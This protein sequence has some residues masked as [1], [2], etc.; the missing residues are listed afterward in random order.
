M[1]RRKRNRSAIAVGHDAFL[2]IV[3]NLVGIL[4]ILVVVLGSQSSEVIETIKSAESSMTEATTDQL[5]RIAAASLRAEAAARDSQHLE[6]TI[7]RQEAELDLHRQARDQLLDL[8]SVARSALDDHRKSLDSQHAEHVRQT[9]Q[10]EQASATLASL[11]STR[12]SIESQEPDVVAVE[13]LPT[14]MAKTVYHDEIHLRIKNNLISVVPIEALLKEVEHSARLS[15]RGSA[16]GQQSETVG[17]IQG[18]IAKHVLDRQSGYRT[19]GGS[20]QRVRAVQSLG[21]VFEPLNPIVGQDID[22]VT[23]GQSA[24]DVELAGRDPQKTAVT[25]WVY[26]DSFATHRQLQRYLYAKGFTAAARPLPQNAPIGA[27]PNGTRSK[28]Q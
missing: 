22:T 26:P 20:S 18:W 28:A 10:F 17:P 19:R 9:A 1:L 3:A 16:N 13:H 23:S 24:I 15:L 4:I 14:P 7:D 12:A 11:Q 25:A 21:I 27:S 6:R 5:S 8:V 2:D